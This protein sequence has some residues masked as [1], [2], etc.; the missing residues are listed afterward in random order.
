MIKI[1]KVRQFKLPKKLKS[2]KK[3]K[4]E[5]KKKGKQEYLHLVAAYYDEDL[6]VATE[7]DKNETQKALPAAAN[8]KPRVKN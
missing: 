3:K 7:D 1:L 5:R 2:K 4:K 8:K 6:K